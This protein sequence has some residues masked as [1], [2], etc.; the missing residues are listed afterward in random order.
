MSLECLIPLKL[1][2]A[3]WTFNSFC[4]LLSSI[5]KDNSLRDF[6][7]GNSKPAGNFVM[8]CV[9]YP[10]AINKGRIDNPYPMLYFHLFG[11]R[12]TILQQDLY[13]GLSITSPFCR[14]QCWNQNTFPLMRKLK[15][16]RNFR[17]IS[18]ARRNAPGNLFL[19]QFY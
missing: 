9:Q 19:R 10:L 11:Q 8:G 17:D 1:P 18:L 16:K 2:A 13:K 5:P 3:S 7:R 15:S 4:K 14:K 12:A 6:S